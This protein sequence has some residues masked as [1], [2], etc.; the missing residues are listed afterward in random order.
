MIN[1]SGFID[2][3]PISLIFTACGANKE[4]IQSQF[5]TMLSQERITSEH[6]R[7]QLN[8]WMKILGN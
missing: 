8:F 1:K 6:I 5:S 2:S 7:K 4:E 3:Y